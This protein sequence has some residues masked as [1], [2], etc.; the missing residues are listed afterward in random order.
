MTMDLYKELAN[1][2]DELTPE[3]GV[4]S[5]NI[6]NLSL[7]K[8]CDVMTNRIPVIYD[9]CIYIVVQG[10]KSAALGSEEFIYDALNYLVLS[11]PL[12]LECQIQQASKE[13]P[14][15]AV[16]IDIDKQVLSELIQES[17]K[18][19]KAEPTNPQPGIFV[20]KLGEDIKSTLARLLSLID[21]PEQALVLGKL[22]IKELIFHV[23]NGAQGASLRA[24]AFQDRQNFQ[25]AKVIGFIQNHYSENIEVAELAA[26]ANMSQSSF[27]SYFKSVT[28]SSPIQY[29]K[30]IRLHAARRNMLFN[31]L[32]ASDAAYHVGYS[33]P[34]QFSR[35]YRRLFGS[36]PSVDIQASNRN[37][38]E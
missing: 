36:P 3:P 37:E 14:Y 8:S 25:I 2:V 27:H 9:P 15:L 31:K 17:T 6:A 30:A 22:T 4:H 34:S 18:P 24:F 21:K 20:S 12:P 35:E 7:I 13:E 10:S 26:K 5:T 33:S 29:I 11:V 19:K 23:L 1:R 16:K 38:Y 28:S 32:S